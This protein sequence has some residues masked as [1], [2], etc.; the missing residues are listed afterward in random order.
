[1]VY[2]FCAKIGIISMQH[3]ENDNKTSICDKRTPSE[4]VYVIIITEMT[5]KRFFRTTTVVRS[6]TVR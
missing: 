6:K 1:M 3:Y 2:F 4:R 5:I